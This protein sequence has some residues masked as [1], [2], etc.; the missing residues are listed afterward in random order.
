[1]V[2]SNWLNF[3]RC[4]KITIPS[5]LISTAR[6]LHIFAAQIGAELLNWKHCDYKFLSVFEMFKALSCLH[7]AK[8]NQEF[9]YFLMPG[10]AALW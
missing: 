5:H 2:S 3:Q 10:Q 1:M 6:K 7:C 8:A 9:K 4:E